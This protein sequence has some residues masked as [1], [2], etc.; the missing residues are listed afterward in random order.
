MVFIILLLLEFMSRP[1]LLQ[2]VPAD[3]ADVIPMRA[4]AV[5]DPGNADSQNDRR[6]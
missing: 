2:I 4:Q 3:C 5:D 1:L 6:R